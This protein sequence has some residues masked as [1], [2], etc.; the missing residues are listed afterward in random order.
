MNVPG[1]AGLPL[2]LSNQLFRYQV[3]PDK[4]LCLGY[5]FNDSQQLSILISAYVVLIRVK[6]VLFEMFTNRTSSEV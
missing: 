1:L 5:V 4:P 2:V 6:K 3:C